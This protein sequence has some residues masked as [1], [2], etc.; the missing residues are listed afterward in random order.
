MSR[1]RPG[2]ATA[3]AGTARPAGTAGAP[4]EPTQREERSMDAI[5]VV[6][7]AVDRAGGDRR[8]ARV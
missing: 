6:T 3:G 1:G 2:T 7:Q 8:C 4:D 5:D